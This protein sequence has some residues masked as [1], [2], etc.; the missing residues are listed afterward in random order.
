MVATMKLNRNE[1]VKKY[2]RAWIKYDYELLGSIFL[3]TA[4]YI[5]RKKHIYNGI[6]EIIQY[7]RR[8]EKRQCGLK[9]R[10]KM[11][12]SNPHCDIA[13]FYAQFYDM[14]EDK[15]NIILGRIIFK[16]DD[17]NKIA[18]LSEAYRKI[19]K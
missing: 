8:N 3:P 4:K 5:I 10:W 2:F 12:S 13:N 18:V 17:D 11:I 16:F 7:W 19:L 9:L 6:E 14:E 1:R 15:Q